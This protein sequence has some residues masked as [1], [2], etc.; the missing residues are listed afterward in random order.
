MKKISALIIT[1][2]FLFVA[3]NPA[4]S[5]SRIAVLPFQNH[6]GKDDYN[7][8]CFDLQDS[9]TKAL[10]SADPEGQ[11]YYVVPIDSLEIALAEYNLDPSNPQY[12]TDMWKAISKLNIKSVVSGSFII[13]GGSILIKAALY[14]VKLKLPHPK[15]RATNIFKDIDKAFEAIDEIVKI[16]SPGLM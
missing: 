3:F 15:Y 4:F 2:V 12:F 8:W 5:Q 14:D 6:D 1:I 9:L 7:L 16:V 13:E 10:I 11:F